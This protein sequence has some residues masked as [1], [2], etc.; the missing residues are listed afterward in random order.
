MSHTLT[1]S[2]RPAVLTSLVLALAT[3]A[4]TAQAAAIANGAFA[5]TYVRDCRSDA[6]KLAGDTTPDKCDDSPTTADPNTFRFTMQ[7]QLADL[8]PGFLTASM[9][10]TNPLGVTSAGSTM[11]DVNASG[12][13]GVITLHQGAYTSTTYARVSGHSDA[14]QS[15]SYDGTGSAN[16]TVHT[17]LTYN[18]PQVVDQPGF[19]AATTTAA[20]MVVGRVRVF[21]LATG[22]FDFSWTDPETAFNGQL[23]GFSEQAALTGSGYVEEGFWEEYADGTGPLTSNVHFSMTAGRTYFVESYLGL[24]AKFGAYV[25]ATHSMVSQVGVMETSGTGAAPQFVYNVEGL[26]ATDTGVLPEPGSVALAGLALAGLLAS[27]RR[28]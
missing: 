14:L 15:F 2:H 5:A 17:V 18:G 11:S 27:R 8:N 1:P 22:S 21:S 24:W 12:A 7:Q 23:L 3:L 4:G 28:C 20:A 26:R 6:A 10:A 13:L 9:T 16:R 19:Q 25:D